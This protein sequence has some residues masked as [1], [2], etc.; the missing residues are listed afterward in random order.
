MSVYKKY[1]RGAIRATRR[2]ARRDDADVKA[3]ARVSK[4]SRGV[5][6]NERCD[7]MMRTKYT[8][9]KPLLPPHRRVVSSRVVSISISQSRGVFFSL[10]SSSAAH[11]LTAPATP[12]PENALSL[13]ITETTEPN[14]AIARTTCASP[15][16]RPASPPRFSSRPA[17]T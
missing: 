6:F 3:S 1:V 10:F 11:A 9:Q 2:F 12:V 5:F 8:Y 15:E 7:V 16:S 14:I 4:Q 13:L 17:H